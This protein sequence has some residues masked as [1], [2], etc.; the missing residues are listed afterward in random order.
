MTTAKNLFLTHV[1]PKFQEYHNIIAIYFHKIIFRPWPLG[2]TVR[3]CAI[4]DETF[5]KIN[6]QLQIVFAESRAS[7]S[8]FMNE[9][10]V[11]SSSSQLTQYQL[12]LRHTV[13]QNRWLLS[14]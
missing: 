3:H 8:R 4:F 13:S 6:G 10:I 7:K 1:V 14:Q 9:I 11:P 5:L 12:P 2:T